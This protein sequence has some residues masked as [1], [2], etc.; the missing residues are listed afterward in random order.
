M[1]AKNN[2][3]VE[4]YQPKLLSGV[5][6]LMLD[7]LDGTQMLVNAEELFLVGID[8]DFK[9]WN[10]D[11]VGDVTTETIVDVYK[12]TEKDTFEGMFGSFCIDLDKLC[13]TQHQIK[14]FCEK[15]SEW[16]CADGW[17]TFF[18]FKVEN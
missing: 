12:M 3:E 9:N 18:L 2:K 14:N 10:L 16:L 15:H 4:Q 11:K 13:L 7:T 17:P 8:K 1:T 6:M 5:E